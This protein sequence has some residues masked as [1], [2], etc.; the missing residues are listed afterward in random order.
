MKKSRQIR[1]VEKTGE[2]SG[3]SVNPFIYSEYL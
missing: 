3:E 2:R 1:N